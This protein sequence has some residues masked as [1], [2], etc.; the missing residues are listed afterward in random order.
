MGFWKG[1][2][3]AARGAKGSKMG[4]KLSAKWDKR[5]VLGAK[6]GRWTARTTWTGWTEWPEE[7]SWRAGAWGGLWTLAGEVCA[8]VTPELIIAWGGRVGPFPWGTLVALGDTKKP[9]PGLRHGPGH[10]RLAWPHPLGGSCRSPPVRQIDPPATKIGLHGL[11]CHAGCDESAPTISL[12]RQGRRQNVN[13]YMLINLSHST[14]IT[15]L[16]TC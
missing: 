7:V 16:P 5:P 14:L 2:Q 4:G 9:G 1:A 13:D 15:P 8:G 12:I 6:Q 3:G 10:S 11:S